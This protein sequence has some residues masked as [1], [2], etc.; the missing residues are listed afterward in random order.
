MYVQVGDKIC[1][2]IK[3]ESISIPVNSDLK[4]IVFPSS[5]RVRTFTVV[6]F[7]A[8]SVIVILKE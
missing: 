4:S 2:I 7:S 6:P 8:I 1:E 3:I 5:E